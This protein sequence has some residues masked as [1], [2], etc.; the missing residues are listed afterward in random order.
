MDDLPPEESELREVPDRRMPM[1][2]AAMLRQGID[3]HSRTGDPCDRCGRSV[4]HQELT[5][6]VEWLGR[7][8]LSLLFLRI[9]CR[10]LLQC[11]VNIYPVVHHLAVRY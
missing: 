11:C 5:V 6:R 8:Q 7:Y 4:S 1:L 10:N 3:Q 2:Q 9:V